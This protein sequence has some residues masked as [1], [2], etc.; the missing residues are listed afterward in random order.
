MGRSLNFKRYK[1]TSKYE[2]YDRYRDK[3]KMTSL[4]KKL[5]YDNGPYFLFITLTFGKHDSV[6]MKYRATSDLI[7]HM[8]KMIYGRNYRESE[9]GISM[10]GFAVFEDHKI[11]VTDD[12]LHVHLL[13]KYDW[14]LG[15]YGLGKLT[16]IFYKAADKVWYGP[17]RQEVFSKKDLDIRDAEDTYR[18]TDYCF[19]QIWD[20]NIDRVKPIDIGGLSDWL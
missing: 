2:Y 5:V 13:I 19:K 1:A 16:D 6:N 20:K 17:N 12:P 3:T 7:H 8:N 9:R 18:R 14:R 10:K 15:K 11:R 4:Y